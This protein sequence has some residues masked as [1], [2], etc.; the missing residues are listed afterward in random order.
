MNLAFWDFTCKWDPAVFVF[1]CLAH[2]LRITSSRGLPGGNCDK[3]SACKT[4]DTRHAGSGSG[5]GGAWRRSPL[6]DSRLGNPLDRGAWGA[7]ADGVAMRRT[8][9]CLGTEHAILQIRP[10][11]C[12]TQAPFILKLY[13]QIKMWR[14]FFIRSFVNGHLEYPMYWFHFLWLHIQKWNYWI[15]W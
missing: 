14:S 11:C 3:E 1:L 5:T 15:I 2:S 13:G 7:T 10:C 9:L 4:G 12:K 6:Q 8:Q